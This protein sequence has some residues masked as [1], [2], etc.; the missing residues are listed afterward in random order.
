M[1]IAEPSARLAS[2]RT[3]WLD[4]HLERLCIILQLT[5]TQYK[6]AESKY[7]AVGKWLS[8][9][10]SPLFICAPEIYPQG[11]MLLGTTI[12]PWRG[13]EFDLDLVCQ[14]HWCAGE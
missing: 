10:G 7:Q 8:A 3:E 13:E 5:S 11:S 14:L 2:V 12:R 1:L 9:P 6:D 4:R